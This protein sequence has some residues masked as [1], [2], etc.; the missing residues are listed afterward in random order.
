MEDF[1]PLRRHGL[2]IT[3]GHFSVMAPR[4]S[5]ARYQ[6]SRMTDRYARRI[7]GIHLHLF[8]ALF[9]AFLVELQ[10]SA[11]EVLPPMEIGAQRP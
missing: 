10:A 2:A 7:A 11:Q 8:A 6:T 3:K 9:F 1:T 5:Y 4:N